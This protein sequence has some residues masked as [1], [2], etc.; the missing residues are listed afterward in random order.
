MVYKDHQIKA[1]TQD[2]SI[3][4]E[5]QQHQTQQDDK[6]HDDMGNIHS[7]FS[8]LFSRMIVIQETTLRAKPATEIA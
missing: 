5:V 3:D 2:R 1:R 8:P 7:I 4:G 6:C